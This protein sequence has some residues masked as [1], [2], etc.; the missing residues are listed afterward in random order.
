MKRMI[1]EEG[2]DMDKFIKS[3]GKKKAGIDADMK[4]VLGY[5]N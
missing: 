2:F 1:P 5:L 3:D 4:I